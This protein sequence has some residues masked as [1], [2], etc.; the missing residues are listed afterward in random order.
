MEHGGGCMVV[1][2]IGDVDRYLGHPP[3]QEPAIAGWNCRSPA[4][5]SGKEAEG[6]QPYEHRSIGFSHLSCS[7]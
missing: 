7:A 1:R 5:R 3:T 2:K 6:L 4:N